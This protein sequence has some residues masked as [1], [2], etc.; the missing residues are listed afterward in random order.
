MAPE[1]QGANTGNNS[2]S[3]ILV[4]GAGAAGLVAT[5]ELVREG[6]DVVVYE[7]LKET[8]GVWIYTAETESDPLGVDPQRNRVHSSMY[9]N[10][11]T[12]LPREIMGYLDFPFM[13]KQGRDE[14]RFPGHEEVNLYLKDFAE[15]YNLLSLI[16]FDVEVEYVGVKGGVAAA[17]T[18]ENRNLKWIVRSRKVGQVD[19]V[20]EEIF[21][22]VVICNGHYAEPKVVPIPGIEGWPGLHMHSHNYRV[23]D[24]FQDKV[25]VIVGNANSGGDISN[26]VA[27]VAKQVHICARNWPADK[28]SVSE[29]GPRKNVWHHPLVERAYENGTVKF[30]DGK[31][32]IA[33]AIIQCTGYLYAF[34]FL[35]A[36][37]LISVEDGRV[38]PLYKHVFIPSL[39]PSLSFVGLPSKVVPF[40]LFQAQVKWI[41]KVLTG[42]V[43]LPSVSVMTAEVEKLYQDLEA[44]GVPRYRTL[45]IG[46]DAFEYV[47]WLLEQCGETPAESW[48]KEIYL[49][50]SVNRRVNPD[51]RDSWEDQELLEIANA[52]LHELSEKLCIGLSRC[53]GKS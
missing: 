32:A 11:R 21:D 26:E 37:E 24:P 39:A 46:L 50:T 36:Q 9:Q 53:S 7:Q 43:L 49:M 12:N 22:G 51:Y 8:G 40:P 31:S 35:D 14:R 27:S 38:S 34:P 42:K 10:L 45:T 48:R 44:K 33:D 25:V 17:S 30:Q 13:A 3:R 41:A 1:A 5:L 52:S 4:I 18:T 2:S 28:L 47:D 23:P 20:R 19:Q 6:L 29:G 16:E 15:H